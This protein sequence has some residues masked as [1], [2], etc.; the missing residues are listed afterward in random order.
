MKSMFLRALG[1]ALLLAVSLGASAAAFP[2]FEGLEQKLDLRPEQKVQ[3][4]IAVAATQRAL[5][6][7]A[8]G[9]LQVKEQL[10][11]ELAKPRP[12]VHALA[13]AHEAAIEQSRPLF[14]AAGEEWKRL[15]AMLDDRQVAIAKDFLRDNLDRIFAGIDSPQ[16]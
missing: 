7:V 3:F 5:L 8:F 9:A 16:R 10:I 2:R 15:L 13:R 12:D 1:A 6:S 4:D 14:R 11:D